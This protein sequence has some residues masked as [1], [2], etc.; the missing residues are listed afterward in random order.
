MVLKAAALIDYHHVKRPAVPVIVHQ[1]AHIFAVDDVQVR[2][3]VQRPDPP[4]LASKD[5]GHPEDLRVV[6]FLFFPGP[7]SLCHF[8]R[9]N[10]KDFTNQEP[11][12]FQLPD[13][14]QGCHCFSK[15]HI[16][17]QRQLFRGED[18]VNA[19]FLIGVWLKLHPIH[20]SINQTG[21]PKPC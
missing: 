11:V 1:P 17:E 10:H 6:P 12:A 20:P 8:F 16:Q 9:G 2:R 14:R 7:R 5:W 13:S 3:G 18:P 4:C 21:S 19:M 15:P